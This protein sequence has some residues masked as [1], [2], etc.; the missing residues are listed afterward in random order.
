MIVAFALTLVINGASGCKRSE[1]DSFH[2]DWKKLLVSPLAGALL[3]QQTETSPCA[4]K[5]QADRGRIA[6]QRGRRTRLKVDAQAL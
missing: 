6:I 4:W 2:T 5:V 3:S 1:L